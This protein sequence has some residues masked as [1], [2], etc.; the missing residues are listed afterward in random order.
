MGEQVLKRTDQKYS[1]I[2]DA[3]THI[4]ASYLT[5]YFTDKRWTVEELIREMDRCGV[6]MACVSGGGLPHEIKEMNKRTLEAVRRYPERLIGFVRLSPKFDDVLEELDYYIRKEG[7][8]GIKL[9]PNQD[10]YC[11][12]REP[13]LELIY[14]RAAKYKVPVMIHSGTEPWSVAGQ[15]ADQ[16]EMFP[17]VTFI[18]AHSG[19]RNDKHVLESARRVSNLI[20]ETSIGGVMSPRALGGSRVVY[21][22]DWPTT[23]MRSELQEVFDNWR[24]GR[25]TDEEARGILGET[26]AGIL[27]IKPRKRVK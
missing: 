16:A 12:L 11:L 5:C 18:M 6:D 25:L 17:D 20:L 14:E 7:F 27:G 22:S 1:F 21:G 10:G 19:L 13:M 24:A 4:G 15:F 23:S 9:H 2:L 3:H 8:K 26:M